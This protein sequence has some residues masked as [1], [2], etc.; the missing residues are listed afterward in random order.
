MLKANLHH[1]MPLR[2]YKLYENLKKV[3]LDG[4]NIYE[5]TLR[6]WIVN[7]INI[8]NKIHIYNSNQEEITFE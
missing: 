7:E 3:F 4:E 5:C 6:G 1:I 8:E 2:Y